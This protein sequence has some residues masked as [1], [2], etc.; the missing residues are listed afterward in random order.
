L[1]MLAH[2]QRRWSLSGRDGFGALS[3]SRLASSAGFGAF[4]GSETPIFHYAGGGDFL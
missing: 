1:M 3:P 2:L 4:C